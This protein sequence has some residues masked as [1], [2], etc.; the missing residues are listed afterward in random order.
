[1]FKGLRK[2]LEYYPILKEDEDWDYGFLLDLIEFKLKR[3]RDYFWS[4]TIVE[5]EKVWGDKCQTLINLLYAGYKT[6]IVE[7]KDL[8]TYV[9][10]KNI[11]KLPEF[12]K[13]YKGNFW[14]KYG[15]AIVR[16]E[17]AKRLFWKYLYYNIEYL[18]E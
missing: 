8:T 14:D 9:N 12:I 16:E 15:L 10:T 17:K 13:E 2:T 5:N 7:S 1:M 11:N 3:M 6:D 4:H 18:W